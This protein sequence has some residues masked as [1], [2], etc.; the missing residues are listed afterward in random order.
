MKRSGLGTTQRF[1]GNFDSGG[2]NGADIEFTSG[3]QIRVLDFTTSTQ[4]QLITTAVYR[5]PSSWYHVLVALDTTQTTSSNRLKLYINGVQVTVFGTET[6][7]GLNV[8]GRLNT[9]QAHG[10]GRAGAY[11]ADYLS[12]YLAN[13]HFVDGQALTP[14]VFGY[15]KKGDGYIS[16]GSTQATDFKKG[17]W[18]P[19]A[20]KVIKSVIN[21][22]GGFGGSGISDSHGGLGGF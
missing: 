1:F 18:V 7:P 16:A 4:W 5:D 21:A 9:A 11:N 20:P 22:R 10:L 19:K 12:G 13:V 6:Y 14:D 3:D 15:H 17:Q 8:D 2:S